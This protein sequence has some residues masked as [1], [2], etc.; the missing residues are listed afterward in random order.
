VRALTVNPTE[1]D[2]LR[3][4]ELDEPR[5]TSGQLLVTGVAVG[6]CATDH[7]I[8]AGKHG[9]APVGRARLVLGHESLGRVRTAPG[10]SGFAPGDLVVGVVR[11]PDPEPCGA[12]ARGQFD[13]C[14]NGRY[15]ER[16]IK[17]LDGFAAE[18]WTIEPEYC[19]R[20]DDGIGHLGV[21]LEPA[22]VVAKAWAQVDAVGGRSWF[23][24]GSVLVTGA[25]PVGLLAA[26]IATRRGLDVHVLDQARKGP[27]P[28]LVDGLGATYHRGAVDQVL[29]DVRPDVVIEATGAPSVV[30][31]VLEAPTPYRVTCLAGLPVPGGTT[32]VSLASA[33]HDIVLGNNVVVG[34]INANLAHYQLAAEA[35]AD[36]DRS[37]L[38]GVVNRRVPLADALDA[39]RPRADDVKVVIDLE[40]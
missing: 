22:S 23:D 31:A 13:M 26:L 2:G 14:R 12:C 27:K 21:L 28:E 37:W 18:S 34:S 36:A 32:P 11:R 39:F 38:T 6:V 5:P 15:T 7:E 1:P 4:E 3:V 10:G 17:G 9:E 24:P 16:G 33:V 30:A 19:V 8:L 40:P 29:R 25:G 20:V 35:L